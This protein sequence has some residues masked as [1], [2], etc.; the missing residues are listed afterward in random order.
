[1]PAVGDD[2][3]LLRPVEGAGDGVLVVARL[4]HGRLVRGLPLDVGR[5]AQQLKAADRGLLARDALDEGDLAHGDVLCVLAEQ[6]ALA[7][8]GPE[9]RHEA[10]RRGRGRRVAQARARRRQDRG[11]GVLQQDLQ[12]LRVALPARKAQ[13]VRAGGQA[14]RHR[15]ALLTAGGQ[16]HA[17]K[18][19]AVQVHGVQV[20]P[21]RRAV[22]QAD[23]LPALALGR[24]LR[25]KTALLL[26]RK[27]HCHVG[28][29]P[30]LCFSPDF[31]VRN[32]GR[33]VNARVFFFLPRC[34]IL[35][36]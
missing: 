1:M 31:I 15:R 9:Q 11:R 5:I 2:A 35:T 16:E 6:H 20:A 7:V 25:G 4:G 14:Q 30:S 21:P 23:L 19:L 32:N 36:P 29:P 18:A 17:R 3:A 26:E 13:F 8:E 24:K 33:S 10:A 12:D 28:F 34:A 22:D 27:F